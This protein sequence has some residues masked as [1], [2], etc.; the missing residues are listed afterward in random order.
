AAGVAPS[1]TTCPSGEVTRRALMPQVPTYQ[2]LPWTWNGVAGSSQPESSRQ[3]GIGQSADPAAEAGPSCAAA[4][5]AGASP[6][7]QAASATRAAHAMGKRRV[8]S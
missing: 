3:A 7:E 8:M 1:T 2:V 6:A 4:V 5:G